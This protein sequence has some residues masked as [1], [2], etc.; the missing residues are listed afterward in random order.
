MLPKTKHFD[1]LSVGDSFQ[2][3]DEPD[4]CRKILAIKI[5]PTWQPDGSVLIDL[6][7]D[8]IKT[9]VALPN[10]VEW[11]KQAEWEKVEHA[12]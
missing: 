4:T 12:K 6:E 9:T 10:L 3:K 5:D 8:D 2:L 7:Q 11:F 1:Y